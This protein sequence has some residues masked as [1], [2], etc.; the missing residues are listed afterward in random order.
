MLSRVFFRVF[1]GS[2]TLPSI[3]RAA[4]KDTGTVSV[5]EGIELGCGK[6]AEDEGLSVVFGPE[7]RITR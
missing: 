2:F 5:V 1:F 4:M 7:Q 3:K 6:R